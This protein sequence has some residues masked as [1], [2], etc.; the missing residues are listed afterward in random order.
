MYAASVMLTT[1]L[2]VSASLGLS[3]VIPSEL[4]ITYLII[5]DGTGT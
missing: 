3:S 1:T 4:V 5:P 2:Y